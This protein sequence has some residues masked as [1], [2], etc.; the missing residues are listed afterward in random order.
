MKRILLPAL[1]ALSCLGANAKTVVI[2]V[3]TADEFAAGH[4]DGA[5]NIDH[6]VIAQRIGMAGVAKDDEVILYCR[7]GRRSAIAA[8]TLKGMGFQ[9][10][11]G[12]RRSGRCT[13]EAEEVASRRAAP[14]IVL[15]Q[16]FGLRRM[17]AG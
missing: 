3:R 16:A 13:P 14:T 5:L 15:Q 4:L 7:S 9:A 11:E 12:L 8:E 2:D 1:L 17:G 10:S 6:Q